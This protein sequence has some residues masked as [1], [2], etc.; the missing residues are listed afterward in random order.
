[1]LVKLLR[2]LTEFAEASPGEV[3]LAGVPEL[4]ELKA[5][6]GAQTLDL[7][8]QRPEL[9]DPLIPLQLENLL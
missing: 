6:G 2:A 4:A 1:L 3:L 9:V 5:E 8:L 7:R